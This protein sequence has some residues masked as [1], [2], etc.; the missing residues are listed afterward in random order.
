VM[1]LDTD[2][3]GFS[4]WGNELQLQAGQPA[5]SGAQIGAMLDFKTRAGQVVQ[6]KVAVSYRSV[7]QARSYIIGE[8][9]GWGFEQVRAAAR[10]EWA[11]AL[12]RV[13]LEGGT[14]AQRR[15]FYTALYRVHL[16]PNDWTGEAPERYGDSRYFENILCLWDTF[17]TPYPL[18]TL[19]QPQVQTGIVNTLLAYHR[20]DGW[21][22]DAHSAHHHEHVQNGSSADVVIADAYVKQ[23]PGIDWAQAYAAIRKNAFED[24]NPQANG[25]PNQGRLRLDDYRRHGYL[26]TDVSSYRDMQAVSRTLEYAHNDFSVLTLAREFGSAADV[27]ELTERAGNYR[28]LWDASTGFM[29]GR[30]ADGRWHEPFDPLKVE[31]GKQFY[32]GHAWTWSWYVPHDAAGLIAL[33]GS[34]QAF[35]AKLTTAVEHHYEAY[36]E[37]G[38]LQTY[39]FTH[40]GRPDLTQRY[41]RQALRHFSDRPD[42]LPGNDDSGTTSAWLVWAMLGLYPNAGQDW[43]YIGSPVFTKATLQ[44]ADGK[45]LVIE[46]PAS[47]AHRLHVARATLGGRPWP[48]AWLRHGDIARGARLNLQMQAQPTAWGASPPPPSMS[49]PITP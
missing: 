48:Q 25:R 28:K 13:Q 18:L 42:G 31:T 49:S 33:H 10:A 47:S 6:S 22:G 9:P 15:M 7:A 35:V 21:T 3:S 45:Q 32:E 4:T 40:A 20:Q 43:Y 36:N 11:K 30:T 5:R 16:T 44:L 38:M 29:R 2:F 8:L 17:R 24:F 19:I 39:L 12:S 34:Q 41:V 23:L 26:P 1:Q 37:P 27:A 14:D 46:S